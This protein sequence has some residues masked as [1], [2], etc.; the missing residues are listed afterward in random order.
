MEEANFHPM[1]VL[2]QR[3]LRRIGDPMIIS[4]LCSIKELLPFKEVDG[5][6]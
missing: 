5:V 4:L 1:I 6:G 2:F 3:Q